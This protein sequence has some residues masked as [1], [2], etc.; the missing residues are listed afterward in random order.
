MTYKV[1]VDD[2]FHFM[3][4]QERT[5]H[6]EFKTLDAAIEACKK[7][8]DEYLALAYTPGMTAKDLYSNY[9]AFGDDPWIGGGDGVPFSAWNYAKQ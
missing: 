6:G 8:V 3:D 4:E 5:A 2:N 7:I 1:I 9:V